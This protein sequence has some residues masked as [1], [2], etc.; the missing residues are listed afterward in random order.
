[1]GV[2]VGRR[3]GVAVRVAVG[4]G[5]AVRVG[6]GVAKKESEEKWQ[7]IWEHAKNPTIKGNLTRY[8]QYREALPFFSFIATPYL[9]MK[10]K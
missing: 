3:V 2:K 8:R 9:A 4:D 10:G 7:K 5:V 1:V 6:V